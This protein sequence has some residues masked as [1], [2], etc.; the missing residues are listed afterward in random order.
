MYPFRRDGLTSKARVM[1]VQE[2]NAVDRYNR[3][4][5][6]NLVPKGAQVAMRSGR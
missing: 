5:V 2:V 6:T 1:Q 3:L 4:S